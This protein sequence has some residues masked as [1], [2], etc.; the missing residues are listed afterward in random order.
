MVDRPASTLRAA[1]A[2]DR[3]GRRLE[4]VESGAAAELEDR[5]ARMVRLRVHLEGHLGTEGLDVEPLRPVEIGCDGRDVVEPGSDG[6][7]RIMA[8]AARARP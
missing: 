8:S 3:V 6:H 4:H 1:V 2:D 5:H 7:A